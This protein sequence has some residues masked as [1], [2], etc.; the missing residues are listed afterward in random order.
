MA[1]VAGVDYGTQSVRVAI[2]DSERGPIGAGVAEYPVLRDRADPDFA[3]QS[4]A[5]HMDALVGATRPALPDPRVGGRDV[6]SIAIDTTGS[7]VIPVGRN[8]EP[9]GD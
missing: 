5:A 8:L 4:H 9:L 3:A 6:L 7:T 2:V 1:I